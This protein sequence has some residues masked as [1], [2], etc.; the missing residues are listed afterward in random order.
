MAPPLHQLLDALAVAVIGIFALVGTARGLL[1]GTL[2]IVAFLAAVLVGRVAA[3]IF[4]PPLAAVLH[5]DAPTTFILTWVVIAC[6]VAATLGVLLLHFDPWIEKARIAVLDPIC[7]LVLGV[8]FGATLV[9]ALVLTAQSLTSPA[10]VLAKEIEKSHG[11]KFTK[12][13]ADEVKPIL[14]PLGFGAGI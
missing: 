13:V 11:G 2:R 7:G 4:G 12:T 6:V 9:V 8:A 5:W 10:S 14:A 3:P 1:R